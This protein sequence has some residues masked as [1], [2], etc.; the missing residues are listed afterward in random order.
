M[1]THTTNGNVLKIMQ[2][3]RHK[4]YNSTRKYIHAIMF[5]EQ[6]YEETV[7]TTVDEIRELGKAGWTKYDELTTNGVHMHFYRK[8]KRFGGLKKT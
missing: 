2:M 3:L 1:L 6:D 4:S 7:A 5:K 8:P